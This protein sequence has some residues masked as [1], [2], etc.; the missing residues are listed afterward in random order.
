MLRVYLCNPESGFPLY[1]VYE[2]E[3]YTRSFMFAF[4]LNDGIN[5][6]HSIKI[7]KDDDPNPYVELPVK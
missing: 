6:P 4:S 2:S 1:K 7:F 5:V 3:N